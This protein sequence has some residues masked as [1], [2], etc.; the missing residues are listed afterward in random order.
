MHTAVTAPLPHLQHPNG[1]AFPA[2]AIS[3]N[4]PRQRITASTG[5]HAARAKAAH[6]HNTFK[7]RPRNSVAVQGRHR[8]QNNTLESNQQRQS[9]AAART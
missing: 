5:S 8:T 3:L 7:P 9:I 2:G 6:K 1:A 4:R